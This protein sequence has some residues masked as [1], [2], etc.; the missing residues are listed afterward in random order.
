MFL[1]GLYRAHQRVLVQKKGLV[2]TGLGFKGL[3]FKGLGFKGLG[4]RVCRDM[5]QR[6]R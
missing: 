5:V 3:G 2:F 4:F 1:R 6:Q